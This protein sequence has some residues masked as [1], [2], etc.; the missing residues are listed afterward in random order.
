[1]NNNTPGFNWRLTI[2]VTGCQGTR[3]DQPQ[4]CSVR[5]FF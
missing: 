2:F 1:M 5:K 4:I 3:D